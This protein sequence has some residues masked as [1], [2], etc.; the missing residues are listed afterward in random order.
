MLPLARAAARAGLDVLITSGADLT[1]L[2]E[3]RG[4]AAHAAGPTLEQSYAAA[5]ASMAE[6]GGP[7]QFGDLPPEQEM[8]LSAE[9]FFGAAAVLRARD[10]LPK[11]ADHRPDLVI[12]DNLELGAPAAAEVL[13]IPHVT[14]S[15]GPIVPGTDR[16]SD[17]LGRTLSAA[18]LPDPIQ[19][20]F[21]APYVDIC[22]PSLQ[23]FGGSAP[24][25]QQVTLRPE[26]GEIQPG[27]KLPA[28]FADLPHPRTIYLTLGTILNQRPEVFRAV[29]AGCAEHPVNV[30]TTLGPGVDPA[31]LGPQPA[32]VLI[33]SYLPQAL[34]LEHCTAVV[35]HV[36]AGTMLGALCFGLPQLALP[37]GTDQPYN[38]A[39]LVASGAGIA[40]AP[41]E[42][43]PGT[44][45]V[46]LDRVLTE[47]GIRSHAEAIRAEITGMPA[48][49]A[50]LDELMA[51]VVR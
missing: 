5:A 33:A 47:P 35:S 39:A 37:Q 15:Y 3:R 51:T 18:D 11:M 30:V 25:A 46:S 44:I 23:P 2:I 27:D 16:F 4:F 7:T 45:A 50:V 10:L 36:G 17:V 49:D 34:V 28:G 1:G 43:T 24:W 8:A 13:G 38:A 6:L 9:F 40:L 48:A 31:V 42:I 29:L 32:S 12:H 21:R 19:S 20:V 41:G 22:P 14:H 26:P